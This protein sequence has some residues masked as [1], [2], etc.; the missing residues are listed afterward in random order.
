MKL[1][2]EL[3]SS[4]AAYREIANR[5]LQQPIGDK[6]DELFSRTFSYKDQVLLNAPY[7]I[8]KSIDRNIKNG[9]TIRLEKAQTRRKGFMSLIISRMIR[10]KCLCPD[11][12]LEEGITLVEFRK[13]SEH[14]YHCSNF[15]TEAIINH[16]PIQK[17]LTLLARN[18]KLVQL[19]TSPKIQELETKL[20]QVENTSGKNLFRQYVNTN[21]MQSLNNE[22]AREKEDIFMSSGKFLI[23]D[24]CYAIIN[25]T[26]TTPNT[27]D[28]RTVENRTLF[29]RIWRL[30]PTAQGN[31]LAAIVSA[32]KVTYEAQITESRKK[33]T[34]DRKLKWSRKNNTKVLSAQDK[35]ELVKKG[36]AKGLTR[37]EVSLEIG[38]QLRLVQKYWNIGD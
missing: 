15:I 36:K 17:R 23:E 32:Y 11:L 24:I 20:S 12:L 37:K 30:S 10:F 9:K 14:H 2:L 19:H 3:T 27:I 16:K 1:K 21:R 13:D 25:G 33:N 29:N 18:G 38:C 28:L 34:K 8:V 26:D 5:V 7:E 4:A 35:R 22:L 6:F 31:L